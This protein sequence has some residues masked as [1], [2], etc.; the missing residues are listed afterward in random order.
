MGYRDKRERANGAACGVLAEEW[1]FRQY[2]LTEW[3]VML[4]LL[5]EGRLKGGLGATGEVI[6]G[7]IFSRAAGS[8][9]PI[10]GSLLA[11]A[12]FSPWF[13][14]DFSARLFPSC[15]SST[16]NAGV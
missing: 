7:A 5:A 13:E 9:G 2:L 10:Y 16:G 8:A 3:L 11:L 14:E 6:T 1:L 4:V 12:P 15:S